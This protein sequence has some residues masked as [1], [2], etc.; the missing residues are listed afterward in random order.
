MNKLVLFIC[1]LMIF[2]L[3]GCDTG[4]YIMDVEIIG[5]PEKI[6]Y[7]ANIDDELDL[8]GFSVITTVLSGYSDEV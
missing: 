1:V 8:S 2:S 5:S 4:N 6:V 7:I 3:I